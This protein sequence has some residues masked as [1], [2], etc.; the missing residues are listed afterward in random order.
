MTPQDLRILKSLVAVAWADGRFA[1]SESSVLDGLLSAFGASDAEASELREWAKRS[2]S[3]DDVPVD[4]LSKEDREV[5]LGNAAVMSGADGK[6]AKEEDAVLEQLATRLG[7]TDA[8]VEKIL[9]SAKDGALQL[10]TRGLED[11]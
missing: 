9:E 7:F 3:L 2:R 4:E 8:E 1:K 5:L 6:R 10:G 11:A